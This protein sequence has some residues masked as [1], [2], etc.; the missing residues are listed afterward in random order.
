[1]RDAFEWRARASE[2][3]HLAQMASDAWIR[4]E[5]LKLAARYETLAESAGVANHHGGD[6][7]AR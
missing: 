4:H 7:G 5:L 2:C 1:M 3:R 6:G